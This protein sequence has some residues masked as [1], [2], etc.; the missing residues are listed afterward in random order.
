MEIVRKPGGGPGEWVVEDADSMRAERD[1]LRGML[2]E[3]AVKLEHNDQIKHVAGLSAWWAKEKV[4]FEREKRL[5]EL[6]R[7][8][9]EIEAERERLLREA[10]RS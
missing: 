1:R 10:A 2:R 3:S 5:A 9:Q 7:K 6:D 4:V 8:Q